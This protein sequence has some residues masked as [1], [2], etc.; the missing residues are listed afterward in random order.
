MSTRVTF[1]KVKNDD[2]DKYSKGNLR[3]YI[4]GRETTIM[5]SL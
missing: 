5:S 2:K 4:K 3:K 1:I